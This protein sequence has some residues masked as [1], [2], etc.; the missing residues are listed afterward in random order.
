[1]T[2]DKI[3]LEVDMNKTALFLAMFGLLS[4]SQMPKETKVVQFPYAKELLASI[5]KTPERAPANEDLMAE[6]EKS[7]RRVYFTSLYHQYLSLGTHIDAD[8]TIQSCPQ[9]H[10]DK[11]EAD[12]FTVPK[13]VFLKKSKDTR[14][15]KEYFPELAFNKSF[16]ISD[17]QESI[18][19][20]LMTLCEEG[21]SDNFFKFDNL[22]S[23]HSHKAS[24]HRP[25]AME[26][27]LK[28]PIFANFYL[29]KMIE[30]KNAFTL[31]HPDEKRFITMTKT[32]WFESYVT[33]AAEVRKNI[34]RN[35]MVKR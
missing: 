9:F 27:V 2:D 32:H 21:V 16:S 28:I 8:T 23:H 17:Y 30:S 18:R 12:S 3:L 35:K 20:E 7:T 13:L 34:L 6:E 11:V 33:K 14:A 25:G 26:S 4:C 29:I 15:S 31:T 19:E 24:F 10:H 5:L 1:M 22:V